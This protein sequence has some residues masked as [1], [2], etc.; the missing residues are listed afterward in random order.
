M[1]A[2]LAPRFRERE[3]LENPDF[4]SWASA[5][6]LNNW[7]TSGV[8]TLAQEATEKFSGSYSCKA[9]RADGTTFSAL[10]STLFNL[11]FGAWFY[12]GARAKG[13]LAMTQAIRLRFLNIRTGFSWNEATQAWSS[14]GSVYRNT[15]TFDYTVAD[16]WIRLGDVSG[17]PTDAYRLELAGYFTGT[18]TDLAAA[19]F[20]DA[21]TIF[22]P[23]AKPIAQVG[24]AP[25]TY[26]GEGFRVGGFD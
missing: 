6:A 2:D 25:L 12:V 4:E 14:G 11:P 18:D 7:T 1:S 23:F 5:S 9:T 10:F 13:T 22:G 19:V 24:L 8:L 21:A 26:H 20:Y 17:I 15:V 16:A 3:W